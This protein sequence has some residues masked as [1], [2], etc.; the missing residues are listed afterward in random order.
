MEIDAHPQS[1]RTFGGQFL[2]FS[3]GNGVYGVEVL[4]VQEIRGYGSVT[5]IA[6]APPFVKGVIN[7]RGT[8]VPIVDLRLKFAIGQ[9]RYD[10][11]TVVIILCIEARTIGVVVDAVSDVIDLAADEIQPAPCLGAVVNADYILGMGSRDDGMM[12]L[13]DIDRLLGSAEWGP[14]NHH[15]EHHIH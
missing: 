4:R 15:T 13:L 6:G 3:L 1:R 8:I 11:F 14:L 2:S 5:S 10:E 12:I 9:A 7:L